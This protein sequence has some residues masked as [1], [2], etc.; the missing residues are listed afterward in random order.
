MAIAKGRYGMD[1]SDEQIVEKYYIEKI[2]K[3]KKELIKIFPMST[4]TGQ[5]ISACIENNINQIT[6]IK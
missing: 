3:I 6:E 4:L 1:T 2:M 5:A